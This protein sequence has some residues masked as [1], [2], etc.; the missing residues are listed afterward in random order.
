MYKR[1]DEA[2]QLTQARKLAL[3]ARRA[4]R[5]VEVKLFKLQLE[6]EG[7]LTSLTTV[8]RDLAA[9]T[10][11]RLQPQIVAL[12]AAAQRLRETKASKLLEEAEQV[13]ARVAAMPPTIQA[14]ADEFVGLSEELEKLI[15]KESRILE[16]LRSAQLE[17]E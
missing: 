13:R 10:I 11:T 15:R 2:F 6:N 9:S 5:E 7:L 8:E 17:H 4:L 3:Q 16:Q 1:Q 12:R 14:L